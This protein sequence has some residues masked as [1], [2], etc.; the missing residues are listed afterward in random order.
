MELGGG[1]AEGSASAGA[2]VAS[3]RGV[4]DHGR[5]GRTGS[6]LCARDRGAVGGSEGDL[7]R[8]RG[9]RRG[10]RAAAG[11]ARE[12]RSGG[13]VPGGG[14]RRSRGG[15]EMRCADQGAS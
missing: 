6:D 4:R 12:E 5:A 2:P 1:G 7:A 3:G 8:T 9:A 14:R 13:G 10:E 11:V 15:G